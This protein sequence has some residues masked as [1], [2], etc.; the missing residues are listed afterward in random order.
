VREED[1]PEGVVVAAGQIRCATVS[2]GA[3]C[4][5]GNSLSLSPATYIPAAQG[6]AVERKLRTAKTISE[7]ADRVR[8][9][10]EARC[11]RFGQQDVVPLNQKT[12]RVLV[13]VLEEGR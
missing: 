1:A 11:V 10:V 8:E 6:D 9:M 5:S 2:F 12:V 7:L 3:L 13:E 4:G